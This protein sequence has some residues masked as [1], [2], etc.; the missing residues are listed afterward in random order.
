MGTLGF[1]LGSGWRELGTVLVIA[2]II[3]TAALGGRGC[4]DWRDISTRLFLTRYYH[5]VGIA[6]NRERDTGQSS[7]LERSKS[8]FEGGCVALQVAHVMCSTTEDIG[9]WA[10]SSILA[11]HRRQQTLLSLR[12]S[13][14]GMSALS[15]SNDELMFSMRLRSFMLAISR[16]E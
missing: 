7:A 12:S 6:G 16:R 4:F 14:R 8:G 11:I 10:M 9:L 3:W 15:E 13:G 5:T 1:S 2:A